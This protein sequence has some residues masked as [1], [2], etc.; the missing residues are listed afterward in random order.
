[1]NAWLLGLFVLG[2]VETAEA[3]GKLRVIV[4][5]VNHD[6]DGKRYPTPVKERYEL[7]GDVLHYGAYFGNM[8]I[9]MNHNDSV[10]WKTGEAGKKVHAA[11]ATVSKQLDKIPAN[12][13]GVYVIGFQRGD[14]RAIADKKGKA[15]AAVDPA[16]RAMIAAFEKATSRP[17]KAG[18]LPQTPRTPPTKP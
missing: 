17:L 7:E 10:D 12:R 11:F 4:L 14:G 6:A 5:E 1:M 2:T 9:E 3:E 15:W 13:T 8:P 18:D 16:F